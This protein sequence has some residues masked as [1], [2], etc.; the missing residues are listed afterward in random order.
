MCCTTCVALWRSARTSLWQHFSFPPWLPSSTSLSRELPLSYQGSSSS[1]SGGT[2]E[3]NNQHRLILHAKY[4]CGYHATIISCEK[5]FN[6]RDFNFECRLWSKGLLIAKIWVDISYV[7][8]KLKNMM[9][10]SLDNLL[11]MCNCIL[12]KAHKTWRV[13]IFSKCLFW[14]EKAC[15][16]RWSSTTLI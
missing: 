3:G 2:T 4:L 14:S 8:E 11:A 16:N 12:Y 1:L 7:K 15:L 10:R 6:S 5:A 13:N 9:D